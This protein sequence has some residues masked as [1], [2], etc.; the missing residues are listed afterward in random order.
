[1]YRYKH[2]PNFKFDAYELK[3]VVFLKSTNWYSDFQTDN[4]CM[5][6]TSYHSFLNIFTLIFLGSKESGIKCVL[7]SQNPNTASYLE[8][9]V[10]NVHAYDAH[11]R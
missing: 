9:H 7:C 3:S 2:L 11:D 1:M 10:N 8:L 5:Y 6:C 4:V